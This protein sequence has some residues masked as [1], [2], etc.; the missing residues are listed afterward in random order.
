MVHSSGSMLVVGSVTRFA[1]GHGVH[2]DHG[3]I[4][5]S[6]HRL[7]WQT[8]QASSHEPSLRNR[9]AYSN[10]V[11]VAA[12]SNA[13]DNVLERDFF[14]ADLVFSEPTQT[15]VRS[16]PPPLGFSIM[17]RQRDKT[18][19]DL[20]RRF[21]HIDECTND[22]LAGLRAVIKVNVRDRRLS[23]LPAPGV[24]ALKSSRPQSGSD[25]GSLSAA[26]RGVSS[27]QFS[28]DEDC[29]RHLGIVIHASFIVCIQ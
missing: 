6:I 3:G 9:F 12:I 18:R 25:R 1:L 23:L 29:S 27:L 10:M 19:P 8:D 13:L 16:T 26:S 4:S 11:S 14:A 22:S 21:C 24:S 20:L 2:R 15:L 5:C 28:V 17:R 7:S